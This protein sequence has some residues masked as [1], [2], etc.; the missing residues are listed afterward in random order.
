MIADIDKIR[1]QR[2]QLEKTT[3]M[4]EEEF[5]ECV[6]LAEVKNDLSYVCKGNG[7]KRKSS[8]IKEKNKVIDEQLF[9][10]EEKKRKLLH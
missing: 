2:K 3:N 9:D 6:R 7:L 8:E 5:V 10:L 4:L 1:V